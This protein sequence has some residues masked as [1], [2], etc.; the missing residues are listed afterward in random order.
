LVQDILY[1]FDIYDCQQAISV[2]LHFSWQ[3]MTDVSH[4][5]TMKQTR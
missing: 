2:D 1:K 5:V 4:Y 3:Q